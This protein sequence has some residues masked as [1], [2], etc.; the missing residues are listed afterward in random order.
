MQIPF[1]DNFLE[2]PL[3]TEDSASERYKDEYIRNKL[4]NNSIYKFIPFSEDED[5][6]N[7]KIELVAEKKLWVSYHWCFK[8][9]NEVATSC[10]P[11]VIAR[12]VGIS[13]KIVRSFINTT[14]EMNDVSCFTYG[15]NDFMW[16]N[17]AN[18][19]DGFC[20]R[21]EVISTGMFYPVIYL[22]KEIIDFTEDYIQ[23]FRNMKKPLK[24]KRLS[25]PAILPWVLKD[26]PYFQEN[27][28]R[29]L[30]GDAYDDEN[31]ELGGR[32]AA[33][34]KSMLGYKG[35]TCSYGYCGIDLKEIIIGEKCSESHKKM[36]LGS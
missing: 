29:F 24:E 11:K 8:D 16:D 23:D 34:K 26:S 35:T 21:F 6:N 30:Y 32:I 27:E 36:L 31:D 20:L 25:R 4:K 12:K 18:G 13:E 9:K 15:M 1:Y 22:N 10:N 3:F 33:R 2:I 17:Y 19:R 14:K 5:L 28:L 7:R